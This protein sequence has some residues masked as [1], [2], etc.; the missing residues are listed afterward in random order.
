M[1]FFERLTPTRYRA[2][3][4]VGGVWNTSEQHIAPA[5]G[6][7]AHAIE[8]DH[9]DRRRHDSLKIAR[10]SYDILGTLPI[11][12]V[13]IDITVTRPGR[14]IELVEARLSH[15]GRTAVV[16]R[17]WL[18][19]TPDTSAIAGTA[20]PSIPPPEA[21]EEWHP[22]AFWPGAFVR[23]IEIRRSLLDEGRAI[24]WIRTDAALIAGELVS[25]AARALGIIDIANGLAP[26]IAIDEAAFPNVDLTVHLFCQPKGSWLGFD[27]MVSFGPNGIGLTHSTIHD[28]EGPVGTVS[29]C[30]T[31]RRRV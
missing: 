19:Q 20:I 4:H 8:A 14:T 12:V 18:L 13:D 29:Q 30:L 16:A 6:L 26:R 28:E 24:S 9:L 23:S 27:T 1:F 2:S 25:P 22:Q 10:L 17:A 5:L 31:I 3:E 7:L 21:V 15:A 11:G